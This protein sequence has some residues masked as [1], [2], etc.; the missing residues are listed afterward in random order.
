MAAALF[1]EVMDE[2]LMRRAP[3]EAPARRCTGCAL[4]MLPMAAAAKREN[5][6]SKS[7]KR[8]PILPRGKFLPGSNGGNTAQKH[9]FGGAARDV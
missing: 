6:L 7:L 9:R 2:M 4:V 8:V 1:C 3:K 5:R